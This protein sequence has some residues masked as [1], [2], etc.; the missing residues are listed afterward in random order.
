MFIQQAFRVRHKLW[1]YII[2]FI[3]SLFII[4]Q[5][6]GVFPLMFAVAYKLHLQGEN[7]FSLLEP[8]V[9]MGTLNSNLTLFLMLLAFALGMLSLYFFVKYVHKQRIIELTTTR[10][11]VD[12]GRVFFGF[13]LVSVISIVFIGIAYYI[14]PE[15]Y[16]VQFELKP[17]LVLLVIAVVMIPIQTSFEEYLFRGYLMQGIGVNAKNRWLPLIITS[18]IF[19]GLHIANPEVSKIGY[20]I[21]V[22]Y[23]GTGLFLGIMTLMDEGMELALGYHAGN[24]LVAALLI[25]AEWTVFQTNSVLKDMSEPTA[26]FDILLPVFVLFPILLFIMSKKYKWTDWKGKLFGKVEDPQ[27]EDPENSEMPFEEF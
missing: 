24:N 14:N 12:W 3:I 16:V 17:F 18:V 22:Y 1:L 19:G 2:G 4:G 25:T 20:I 27:I 6:I 9:L 21:M 8:Q 11:K 26:G 5:F 13:G 10:K 23:I 15:D 7:I